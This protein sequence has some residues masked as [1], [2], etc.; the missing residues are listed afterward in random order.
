MKN[1]LSI[2]FLKIKRTLLFYL[3]VGA[4][5]II[6]CIFFLYFL[7]EGGEILAQAEGSRWLY[8]AKLMQTYWGIFFLPLFITLQ[9]A[10]LAG[11]EHNGKMWKLLFAQ[12]VRQVDILWAKV[13]IAFIVIGISQALMLPLTLTGGLLLGRLN[14]ALGFEPVIPLAQ[15]ALLDGVVYVLSFIALAL[16][17]WVS[18]K[19]ESFV[20]AVSFGIIATVSAIIVVNS[21]IATF[22][23]WTMPG[24]IA[25]RFFDGKFPWSNLFYSLGFTAIV[26]L[27]SL[28]DLMRKETY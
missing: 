19:W 4:P 25:N 9:T 20:T 2:E 13:A 12:P 14:P 27:A 18:L 21:S 1:I 5:L 23:P 28:L 11:T 3:C 22:Y 16:Q 17:V 6:F 7:T 15:I 10:L 24:L 8:Y 26:L